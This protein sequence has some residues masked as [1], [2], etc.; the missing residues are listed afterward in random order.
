M[1]Y[2]QGG[3]GEMRRYESSLIDGLVEPIVL[4]M[5][6]KVILC[7][8]VLSFILGTVGLWGLYIGMLLE[9]F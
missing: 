9:I 3:D 1:I 8:V 7:V 4:P 5:W 6:G 2:E